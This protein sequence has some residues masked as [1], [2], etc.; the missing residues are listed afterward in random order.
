M[1]VLTASEVLDFDGECGYTQPDRAAITALFGE[2]GN[3]RGGPNDVYWP[4]PELVRVSR[5]H[6]RLHFRVVQL[7]YQGGSYDDAD[8]LALAKRLGFRGGLY[9]EL[10]ALLQTNH[11]R[12]LR[13]GVKTLGA[14]GSKNQMG[15]SPVMAGTL[16]HQRSDGWGGPYHFLMIAD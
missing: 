9:E 5:A 6:R 2:I 12:V 13:A 11:K 10:I 14:L 8:V 16:L 3:A 4:I 7:D 15:W 1:P